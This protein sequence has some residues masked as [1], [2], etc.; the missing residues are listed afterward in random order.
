V[1]DD[2]GPLPLP[3]AAPPGPMAPEL[4]PGDLAAGRAAATGS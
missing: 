3:A 1:I 2:G 4:A